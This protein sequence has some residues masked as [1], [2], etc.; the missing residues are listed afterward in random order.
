MRF[1]MKCS[2][3]SASFHSFRGEEEMAVSVQGVRSKLVIDRT[4]LTSVREKS[5]TE[6]C[7]PSAPTDFSRRP[8]I[9]LRCLRRSPCTVLVWSRLRAQ[10]WT[11]DFE[12]RHRFDHCVIHG[13]ISLL[14]SSSGLSA[15]EIVAL[16]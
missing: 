5:K 9:V 10:D 2:R 7:A 6:V 12:L 15:H 4:Q 13:I 8:T 3:H 14:R 16:T 11:R 1:V